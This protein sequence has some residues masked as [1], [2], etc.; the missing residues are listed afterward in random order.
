MTYG[1]QIKTRIDL[2]LNANIEKWT[3][4]KIFEGY[5]ISLPLGQNCLESSV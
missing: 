2:K 4:K 5:N 3:I 1:T